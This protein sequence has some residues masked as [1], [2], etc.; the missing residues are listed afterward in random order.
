M[1]KNLYEKIYFFT[2]IV[3]EI[4]NLYEKIYIFQLEKLFQCFYYCK[5]EV[6][7]PHMYHEVVDLTCITLIPIL[8]LKLM[9]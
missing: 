4:K 2:V 6:K 8:D 9:L 1:L 5:P 3:T 7:L